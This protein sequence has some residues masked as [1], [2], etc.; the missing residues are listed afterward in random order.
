MDTQQTGGGRKGQQG[1]TKAPVKV[2]TAPVETVKG[3]ATPGDVRAWAVEN[4][5]EVSERG[6]V[7]LSL[8]DTFEVETGRKV[9][10]ATV[11]ASGSSSVIDSKAIRAWAVENGVEVGQ[12]GRIHPEVIAAYNEA[13]AA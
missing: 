11:K 3:T 1:N 12:R 2:E 8:I 5:H 4:G 13:H 7:S 10:R 9:E 6:R